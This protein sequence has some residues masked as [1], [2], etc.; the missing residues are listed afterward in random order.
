MVADLCAVGNALALQQ[1]VDLDAGVTGRNFVP[2][3]A[4]TLGFAKTLRAQLGDLGVPRFGSEEGI[5]AVAVSECSIVGLPIR[6]SGPL[7]ART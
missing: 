7:R 5:L 6:Y 1:H 4:K 2:Q 3:K